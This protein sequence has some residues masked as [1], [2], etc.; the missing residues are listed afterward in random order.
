MA[1]FRSFFESLDKGDFRVLCHSGAADLLT[2]AG[3]QE[4]PLDKSESRLVAIS[5]LRR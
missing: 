4:V 5:S 1:D 3:I 2:K